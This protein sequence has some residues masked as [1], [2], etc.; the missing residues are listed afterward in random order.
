MKNTATPFEDRTKKIVAQLKADGHDLRW[1]ISEEAKA[2]VVEA[3]K[4]LEKKYEH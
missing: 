3:I 4:E 1:E 2:I